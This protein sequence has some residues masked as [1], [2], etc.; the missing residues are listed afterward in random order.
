MNCEFPPPDTR[1]A[2]K[3]KVVQF[4]AKPRDLMRVASSDEQSLRHDGDLAAHIQATPFA[5]H[6]P[7]KIPTREWL[8][9]HFLIRRQVSLT[10]APGG[11][12]KSS[13][14]AVE[15]LAQV[16]GRDLLHDVP[17]G[18]LRV[19]LWNGEDPLDELQRR[20]AAA[21][22]HYGISREE[23]AGHLF[24]DSGRN[25]GIVIAKMDRNGVVVAEPVVNALI[26]TIRDNRIDILHIDPFVSCHQVP[27]NDNGA[28]DRVVKTYARIADMTGCAIHL[29]HH[30]RKTGGEAVEVEHARGAVALIAAARAA[31]TLNPMTRE[32]AEKAG[33]ENRFVHVRID[34]GK[35]NLA[36]RSDKARWL[37]IGS[38][39]LWNGP[40]E[41]AGDHVA[42]VT[43]W[44]WADAFDGVTAADLIAAQ[45]AVAAGRWRENF[46]ARDWVGKPIAEALGL[47]LA[48]PADRARVKRLL[49]VWIANGMFVVVTGKDEKGKDRPYVEVGKSAAE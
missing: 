27:E 44:Q 13:L 12:G 10:V 38:V 2:D 17:Y 34:D 25:S 41:T 15:A 33:V 22:L 9:G 7:S 49:K 40:H 42:V 5:W 6:E 3:V 11:T 37:K 29:V 26:E 4:A 47:D 32:E 19:W 8:Y 39:P 23:I 48:K 46:Q 18:R 16:T 14:V 30:S 21:C 28:V 31:R 24:V 36:P 20:I 1:L 43:P 45:Q 35:A